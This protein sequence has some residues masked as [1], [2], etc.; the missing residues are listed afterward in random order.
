MFLNADGIG[1]KCWRALIQ[2]SANP[3]CKQLSQTR[4]EEVACFTSS[5]LIITIQKNIRK[6]T[7]QRGE[8]EA[9]EGVRRRCKP[10][11]KKDPYR[12]NDNEGAEPKKWRH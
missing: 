6:E 8:N 4:I 5:S 12:W 11:L 3:T 7:D 9:I 1:E 2:A 10:T